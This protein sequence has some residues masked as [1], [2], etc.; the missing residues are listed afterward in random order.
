M[1]LKV[2]Y[3]YNDVKITF[4]ERELQEKPMVSK[5]RGLVTLDYSTPNEKW[6]IN[7]SNQLVGEKNFVNL[8]HNPEHNL[9]Q[10]TGKTPA[11]AI[12]N[13]HLTRK[14]GK[15]FE[16][17]AGVENL[18]NYTQKDPIIDWENPFGDNFDAS[19]IYAPITGAMGYL[20]L[21]FGIE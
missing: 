15:Q 3:K 6:K 19:H 7:I 8:T 9:Q 13:A 14:F 4:L 1:D 10:H 12:V 11:Y 18:T 5:H 2:G 17:Y 21:R 20:G 16:I